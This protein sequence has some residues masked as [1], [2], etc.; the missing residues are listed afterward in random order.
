V[1]SKKTTND[2]LIGSKKFNTLLAALGAAN[3]GGVLSGPG[4]VTVFAPTDAAFA[5]LSEGSL[6][7]LLAD[8]P[9]L[10]KL[11]KYHV[12]ASKVMAA[13][14]INAIAD[15]S[16]ITYMTTLAGPS[17]SVSK[18]NGDV[19]INN[20][21]KV[22]ITDVLGSNGVVVHVIDTVLS[23]QTVYQLLKAD[24]K[25]ETLVTAID[26][27]FPEALSDPN[28]DTLTLFAPGNDAFGKLP[29]ET[30]A[31]LLL[32]ENLTELQML[33]GNHVYSGEI[34]LADDSY[35]DM[36][37]QLTA[38]IDKNQD[39][40]LVNGATID[41]ENKI[42]GLNG[43]IYPV[44]EIL[45]AQ[46]VRDMIKH[47]DSLNEFHKLL[48]G[49]PDNSEVKVALDDGENVTLFAPVNGAVTDL[50]GGITEPSEELVENVLKA[51]IVASEDD[52]SLE[53]ADLN[54]LASANNSD[55][56]VKNLAGSEMVFTKTAEEVLKVNGTKF[57]KHDIKCKNGTIHTVENVL[58]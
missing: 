14:I 8:V 18:K 57:K 21:A 6:T 34:Q 55:P 43:V 22:T 17:I 52:E 35:L 19:I 2:L 36:S 39:K 38:Y 42:V 1:L 32:P 47:I 37:S 20:S 49:L 41:A 44:E 51:H 7:A 45:V 13:D 56:K 9:Q 10:E 11:L 26:A 28:G 31:D 58:A 4:P 29:T 40:W 50:L 30:V 5:A 3:L 54:A 25:F 15:D 16:V 27:A 46:S 33:L 12:V 48:G 24:R 23:F 53:K